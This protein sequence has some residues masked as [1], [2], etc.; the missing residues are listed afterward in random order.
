MKRVKIAKYTKEKRKKV[1]DNYNKEQAKIKYKTG[2][3][4][5]YILS[6][7]WKSQPVMFLLLIVE[8]ISAVANSLFGTFT[9]KY[10]VELALGTSARTRLAAICLLLIAGERMS[11]YIWNETT[12]YQGY[13]GLYK[14][15]CH[16]K[17]KIIRK[18]MSTDY[19]NN[20]SCDKSDALKKAETGSDYI[21][22]K[23][24]NTI[25]YFLMAVLQVIAYGSILSLLDPIMLLIVGVP[26]IA[27]YYIERHKMKWIWNMADN[28]QKYD[29]ELDYIHHAGGSFSTAKDVRVYGMDRWFNKLFTRSFDN[30]L[31]WYEQQDEW[32]FRHDLARVLMVYLS[33]FAAYAYVIYMVV[34]G[35]IGAGD[36][37][38]YFGSIS[39]FSSAVRDVFDKYSGFKW[40]SNNISYSREYLDIKDKTNRGKGEKLPSGEC[41]I[42]FRNVSYTYSGSENPTIH[43]ISFTLH[44]G[45]RLALVGL[46]GAGKTTLI[47]LMSG[48]Y[49]PT[50]GEILL[51]GK[52]VNSYN[53][54]EYFSLFGA[55]FQDISVLPVTIAENVAGADIEN[56]DMDRVYDCLKKA[57]LYDKV[58]SLPEKENT[59]LVK[60]VFE[61]ATEFSG[62]QTQKLA[63]ARALYKGGS[64]LLLDEPTAALDPIA[65]Q[66][67]YLNYADFSTGKS[68]VFIS[69]R[70]ASTRFC[71]RI[72]MIENGAIIEEGTHA[73]LMEQCGKYAELFELQSSYYNDK[74]VQSDE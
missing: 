8:L 14:F 9:S 73:E 27:S 10:V 65:E 71:D 55:V 62:G 23:T 52:P 44:K 39:E 5:R 72:I 30:R 21:T 69:H 19:E 70:L 43:N 50:E 31:N 67:M 11:K 7:L 59:R 46:N 54:D 26:A 49:N 24:I 37:V 60:S 53:R 57:G 3:N 18:N 25:E 4:M 29:R 61:N 22:W 28:W 16:M 15:L 64:V 38:L 68:S 13:V 48:L 17:R 74:E 34:Q 32:S 20:E 41:E 33:N 2:E 36:F 66:E 12:D 1:W 35:N 6:E 45:E 56:I 40:L 42:E 63:L 47:K 51:N 58:M